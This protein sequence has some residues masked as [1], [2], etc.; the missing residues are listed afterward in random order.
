MSY[1]KKTIEIDAQAI[2][3]TKKIFDVSTDKEAVNLALKFI[4]DE[5]EIIRTHESLAGQLQLQ[6]LFR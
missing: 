2:K 1:V 6:D 4:C 5:D 3:K